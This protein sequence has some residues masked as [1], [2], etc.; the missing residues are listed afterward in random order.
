MAHLILSLLELIIAWVVVSLLSQVLHLELEDISP[1]LE[2]HDLRLVKEFQLTVDILH[3]LS[4]GV[5][6]L[7]G[8]LPI[9]N[10]IINKFQSFH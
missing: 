10:E 8:W 6:L 5:V 1:L 3:L 7:G 2:V 9:S 4:D